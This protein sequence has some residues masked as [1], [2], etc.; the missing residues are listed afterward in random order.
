M[1]HLNGNELIEMGYETGPH[2]KEML[3]LAN[4]LEENDVPRAQVL[5]AVDEIY[6]EY[7]DAKQAKLDNVVTMRENSDGVEEHVYLDEGANDYEKMNNEAVH[8]HVNVI[9]RL[10]TI[11][12]TAIYPDAC[13]VSPE[14]GTAP[15]GTV[16]ATK[17]AIHPGMHSADICCSMF[18]TSMDK[19]TDVGR[20]MDAIQKVS[21]FGYGGRKDV[22][23]GHG[24]DIIKRAQ[25]NRFLASVKMFKAMDSHLG[26]QGDGNHFFNVGRKESNGDLTFVTHHGS[27]SPGAL[28]YKEG[29]RVAEMFRSELAPDVPKGLAWIPYD[30][31]EGEEYWEALQII[32]AWTRHNH[33]TIHQ[34]VMLELGFDPYRDI[35]DQ[36]WNEHNFVFKKDDVFY[37]A[38]GSTPVGGDHAHDA[39]VHGRT[40]IP[41]NMGEPILIVK[42][43]DEN[44]YGFAPHGAGRYMSR[45]QYMKS[46]GGKTPE[47]MMKEQTSH[48]DARF[49]SGKPDL[50]ELP[51]A[52][53]NAE[54]V[55]RQIVDYKLANIVDRVMPLGSMMAGEQYKPWQDKKNAKKERRKLRK[56]KRR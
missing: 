43:H 10:P 38:K 34:L 22:E 47:Q 12:S 50:S 40:I 11:V 55:E 32:R 16:A 9:R 1:E 23:M 18:L 45:T 26:T 44:D 42:N 2:F 17:N 36:F 5:E 28:L 33:S 20:V 8:K 15:V 52:Y 7:L 19:S 14:P 35:T 53:K 3:A 27:R 25:D 13:P 41:L 4:T 51:G 6:Q 21:H 54:S 39:D 30:T 46:N 48:I 31:M 37:H 56:E 24:S 29:M 49:Y